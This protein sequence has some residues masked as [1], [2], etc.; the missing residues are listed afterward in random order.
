M[1]VAAAV[2]VVVGIEYYRGVKIAEA[3]DV[4]DAHQEEFSLRLNLVACFVLDLAFV[5]S[6][7]GWGVEKVVV[8]D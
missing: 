6:E 2:A 8:S 1:G 7:V 4:V 5:A 3:A